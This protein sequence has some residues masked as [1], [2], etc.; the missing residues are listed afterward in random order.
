MYVIKQI[1]PSKFCLECKGCCRFRD[2]NSAWSP[3]LLNIEI[4]KLMEDGISSLVIT[5]EKHLRV[6]PFEGENN[7]VCALLNTADNK[8]KI[9]QTRPL[10][11]QIYPFVINLR[12]SKVFLAVDLR[13]PFAQSNKDS[14]EFK[15]YSEYLAGFFNQSAQLDLLR[16]NP[17]I[18]QQYIDVLNL[19]EINISCH[20]ERPKG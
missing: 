6:E 17:Q 4:E 12:K 11:C 2:L 5:Q 15:E 16:T 19:A 13:C 20:C 14:E 7:F 9:Y 1:I 8:C 18:I 3:A 10:E